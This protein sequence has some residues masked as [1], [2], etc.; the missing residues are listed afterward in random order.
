M[1]VYGAASG[2]GSAG[3]RIRVSRGFAFIADPSVPSALSIVNVSNPVAPVSV[4]TLSYVG[5]TLSPNSGRTYSH[6]TGIA[7]NGWYFAM[8]GDAFTAVERCCNSSA[9][10]YFGDYLNTN[11]SGA[12][13]SVTSPASTDSVEE[14]SIMTFRASESRVAAVRW[15]TFN[16]NG[17]V[18]CTAMTPPYSCRYRVPLGVSSLTITA[19]AG[20]LLQSTPAFTIPVTPATKTT[21]TGRVTDT[22]GAPISGAAVTCLGASGTTSSDGSFAVTGAPATRPYVSC[23]ASDTTGRVGFAPLTPPIPSGTTQLGTFAI[24]PLGEFFNDPFDSE[25]GGAGTNGYMALSKWTVTSGTMDLWGNGFNDVLPGHGLYLHLAGSAIASPPIGIY[26]GSYRIDFDA[27][28]DG[29]ASSGTV[30]TLAVNGNN[31][32][33]P[34]TTQFTHYTT[35]FSTQFNPATTITFSQL[36]RPSGVPANAGVLIDNVRVTRIF[37]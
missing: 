9:T 30:F 1:A 17:A 20:G 29:L 21:A 15:V 10:L 19:T 37:Q 22:A 7:L 24:A 25:N 13:V 36:S 3:R 8:I 26:Y 33:I 31:L 11:S 34:A 35:G 32:S 18:A 16:V 5:V 12:S 2:P 6:P 14:G 4:T 27:A 28:G 23:R